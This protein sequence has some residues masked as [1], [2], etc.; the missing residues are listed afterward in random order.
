MVPLPVAEAFKFNVEPAQIG[1]LLPEAD[2][3]G[4]ETGVPEQP[5]VGGVPVYTSLMVH[6][7]LSLQGVPGKADP[8]TMPKQSMAHGPTW[9]TVDSMM[10]VRS[11][12]L[13]DMK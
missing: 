10:P 7:L 5:Q 13:R 4:P 8:P 3:D 2:M 6:A 1:P 12:P 9:A 11:C